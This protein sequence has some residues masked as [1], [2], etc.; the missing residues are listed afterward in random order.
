M[1]VYDVEAFLGKVSTMI[2]SA[3][4]KPEIQNKLES[5]NYDLDQ[6]VTGRDLLEELIKL[7]EH[8]QR[9]YGRKSK[10]FEMIKRDQKFAFDTY[11]R[12]Q[13]L[14][15]QALKDSP[16]LKEALHFNENTA[17][18]AEGWLNQASVFYK[19]VGFIVKDFSVY[20]LDDSEL[21]QSRAMI[22]ALKDAKIMERKIQ[23]KAQEAIVQR[24]KVLNV[25][26]QWVYQFNSIA[27]IALHDDLLSLESLGIELES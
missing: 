1:I 14:I 21:L 18:V 6:L 23:Q 13:K 8:F 7:Q 11:M 5:Y 22:E 10:F 26:Q 2:E 15:Y 12:H 3:L 17:D 25:L 9:E 16:G 27:Q 20:D 24:D 4:N 19:K